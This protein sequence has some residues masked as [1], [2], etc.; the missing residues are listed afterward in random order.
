MEPKYLPRNITPELIRELV[1]EYPEHIPD[2]LARLEE[3]R[4]VVIPESLRELKKAQEAYLTVRE[5]AELMEWKLKHGTFRPSLLQLIK[6]NADKEVI[7]STKEAFECIS[8]ALRT[9]RSDDIERP[10]N[11]L[12]KLRG[13]GPATASLILSC[14]DQSRFP[15]F[16]DELY[17]W[18]HWDEEKGIGW[19]RKL[20]YTKGEYEGLYEMVHSDN[21]GLRR[22]GLD[23]QNITALE[24]EQAAYV[25][26]KRAKGLK[27]TKGEK[28]GD[29]SVSEKRQ[30]L[31]RKT[32][33]R[34]E[35]DEEKPRQLR[36]SAEPKKPKTRRAGESNCDT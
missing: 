29:E 31:K 30:T 26:G 25:L 28:D 20:K 19:D 5:L 34:E 8:K 6:S 22:E 21:R 17:R 36:R 12:T 32:A 1:S 35:P 27:P 13:V 4:M 10:I 11:C 18:L 9:D 24:L 3:A 14:Y 2:G 15:F 16:S 23:G 33:N 7:E